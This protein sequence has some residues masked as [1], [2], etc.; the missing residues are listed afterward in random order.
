MIV[1][2]LADAIVPSDLLRDGFIPL[3]GIQQQ[4]VLVEFD[5]Q[6]F[7]FWGMCASFRFSGG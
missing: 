6:P 3:R 1:R 5:F 7:L 4:T 2:E